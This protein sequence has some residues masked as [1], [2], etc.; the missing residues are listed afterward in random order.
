[1]HLQQVNPL[2]LKLGA[3]PSMHLQQVNP[4][5]LEV[6]APPSMH[7]QQVILLHLELGAPPSMHLQQVILL[8]L[9]LGAPPSM[10]LQQVN[11]FALGD[12]PSPFTCNTPHD[13]PLCLE[14]RCGHGAAWVEVGRGRC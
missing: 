10:Y 9:E 1:M 12:S 7:L 13:N 4:L 2:H 14:L 6:G 5:H 8:H 3:P 11:P